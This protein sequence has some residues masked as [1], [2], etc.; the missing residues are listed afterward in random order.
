MSHLVFAYGTLQNGQP[1]H[2]HYITKSE[3]GHATFVGEAKTVEKWPLVIATKFNVPFVLDKPGVGHHIL[4]EV[5]RVDEE[6]LHILD[7]FEGHPTFYQRIRIP[8]TMETVVNKADTSGKSMDTKDN[9]TIQ[10]CYFY[11]VQNFKDE[12]LDLTFY[13]KYDAYGNPN[14]EHTPLA[15]IDMTLDEQKDYLIKSVLKQ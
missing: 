13:E 11:V 15:K 8:V 14:H 2:E 10:E 12:L 7:E 3:K 5:Y 9:S 6:M 4:G 1:Y